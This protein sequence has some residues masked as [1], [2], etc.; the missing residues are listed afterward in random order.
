MQHLKTQFSS[1]KRSINKAQQLCGKPHLRWNISSV[2]LKKKTKQSLI[3]TEIT[4]VCWMSWQDPHVRLY[5]PKYWSIFLFY[6]IEPCLVGFNQP[7]CCCGWWKHCRNTVKLTWLHENSPLMG[8]EIF[9]RHEKGVK[10]KKKKKK[11]EET[12]S[13]SLPV[14]QPP[15][16]STA[17]HRLC[18]LWPQQV[19][20]RGSEDLTTVC[21]PTYGLSGTEPSPRL[22]VILDYF[23]QSAAPR[24]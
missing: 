9:R 18:V 24:T 20:E 1:A 2:L 22:W 23:L 17:A 4:R 7:I 16:F 5:S 12:E 13:C 19:G 11:L 6:K 3:L 21:M 14:S 15:N 8:H 10:K